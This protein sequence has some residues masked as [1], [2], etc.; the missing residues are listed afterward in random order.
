MTDKCWSNQGNSAPLT[1]A[2]EVAYEKF[3]NQLETYRN[4]FE[5]NTDAQK[6]LDE[7]D[8]FFNPLFS[9]LVANMKA[10]TS[11]DEQKELLLKM[12][13]NSFNEGMMVS[14]RNDTLAVADSYIRDVVDAHTEV[15]RKAGAGNFASQ[16]KTLADPGGTFPAVYDY[17]AVLNMTSESIDEKP[18]LEVRKKHGIPMG[19][20][21]NEQHALLLKESDTILRGLGE[22]L[23]DADKPFQPDMLAAVLLLM[24][25]PQHMQDMIQGRGAPTKENSLPSAT[26]DKWNRLQ[27]DY[28]DMATNVGSLI[29]AVFAAKGRGRETLQ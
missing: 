16:T 4:S 15:V 5:V 2:C 28:P 18:A 27:R 23:I 10:A 20:V 7:I 25:D 3:R 6:S 11:V 22:P 13:R 9:A 14:G 19:P 24:M 8:A 1:A 29:D 26:V 17:M 12:M 21:T